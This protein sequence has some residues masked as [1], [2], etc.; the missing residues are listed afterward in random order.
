MHSG[1]FPGDRKRSML[2]IFGFL[3]AGFLCGYLLRKFRVR[4]MSRVTT[5]LIWVLLLFLGLEVG[6]NRQLIESLPTLGLEAVAVA[7]AGVLGSCLMAMVLWKWVSRG[8]TR[9]GK[10]ANMTLADKEDAER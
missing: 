6:C 1:G 7:V 3:L 5:C 9:R 10:D 4:W 8:N 2:I